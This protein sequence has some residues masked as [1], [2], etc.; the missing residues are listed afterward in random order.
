MEAM[1]YYLALGVIRALQALPL[2]WVAWLGRQAG[3]LAWL[4]DA[5]HRRVAL[6]NLTH[7]FKEEKTAP[8]LRAL[9]REHFRRL[10]ENY[11]SAVK[12]ASMKPAALAPHLSFVGAERLR[13]AS[14][15]E[16]PPSRVIAIG[17]FGNF[18]LYAWAAHFI[19][20]YRMVTTY[21]ALPQPRLD[22]LLLALRQQSGCA[23]FERRKQSAELFKMIQQPGLCIGLLTDQHAGRAGVWLPFFGR[24]CSTNPAAAVL[25][26]RHKM[27]LHTAICFRTAL[28]RWQIEVGEEIPTFLN[29][30]R[31][32][33]EDVMRDINRAFE[34]AI[35]RDPA[36][37]F[38]V[39][40]RWKPKPQPEKD[41]QNAPTACAP[42]DAG[43]RP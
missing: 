26:Q 38:W 31:R 29:G 40:R 4:L 19:A 11:A 14:P 28:A 43:A 16:I 24:E 33:V 22:A 5:R 10:G 15:E 39:H 34:T 8:E 32:P 21:R 37:W 18:E 27:P 36:N 17:H 9:T 12:T 3:G 7:A 2:R 23:V 42:G 1:L 6:E 13:A 20:G 41:S 25:A 35:R 30:T